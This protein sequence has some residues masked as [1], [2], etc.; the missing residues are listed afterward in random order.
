MAWSL[1]DHNWLAEAWEEWEGTPQKERDKQWSKKYTMT[2]R[3]KLPRKQK[4]KQDG[5]QEV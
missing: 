4:E 5:K 2:G 3:I 1:D